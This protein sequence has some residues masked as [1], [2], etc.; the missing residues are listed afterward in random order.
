MLPWQPVVDGDIIPTPPREL[1]AA[2]Y[3]AAVHVLAGTN[4][5]EHRLML[6]GGGVMDQ[7]SPEM[8]A[9][10]IAGYGLPVEATLTMYPQ[11]NP[12]ASPGDLLAAIQSDWYWR[13]PAIRLAE[14][15]AQRGM[16]TYMYEFGWPSPQFENRLGACH[17]LEIPFVFNT[18]QNSTEPLLGPAPP[19]PLADLMH[20]AWVRFAT[21]GDPGWPR[22]DAGRRATMKF[23]ETST[24]VDDPRS[25]ER[26]FWEGRR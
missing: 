12:T 22:Y 4:T 16:P 24:V 6:V 15:Y 3:S 18:L 2:G 19:Q 26:V 8:L 11:A 20:A 9:A 13:I 14:A 5:D 21:N 10:T 25:G 17:A 23:A 1:I 7:I